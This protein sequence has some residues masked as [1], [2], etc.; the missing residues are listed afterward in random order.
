MRSRTRSR[1]FLSRL[2]WILLLASTASKNTITHT[3]RLLSITLVRPSH[4]ILLHYLILTHS[5][6]TYV[7]LF[8]FLSLTPPFF[9]FF[10]FLNDPAPPEIYPFPLHDPL[11]I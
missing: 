7:F 1:C 4:L 3:V 6:S 5:L 10:F 2:C 11:P 8:F 9:F